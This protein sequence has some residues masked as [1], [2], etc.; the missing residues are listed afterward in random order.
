MTNLNINI[1]KCRV[2]I[3]KNLGI[4]QSSVSNVISE[5]NTKGTVTSPCKTQEK[6]SYKDRFADLQLNIVFR[7]VNSF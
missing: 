2:I 3:S 7:H 6:K 5:Y 1:W 4:G